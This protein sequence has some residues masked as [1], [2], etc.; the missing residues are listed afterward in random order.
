MHAHHHTPTSM[1]VSM[2][3]ADAQAEDIPSIQPLS[4]RVLIKVDEVADV[5]MGGVFVPEAAKDRPLSGT[6]VRT[7]PGKYDKA[8]EEKRRKMTVSHITIMMHSQAIFIVQALP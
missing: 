4:D 5:T 3:Y 1:S 7:G 8:A 2:S 6:V